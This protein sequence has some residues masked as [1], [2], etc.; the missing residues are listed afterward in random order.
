MNCAY[1]LQLSYD[2]ED[3]YATIES[4]SL[5]FEGEGTPTRE[6]AKSWLV[7]PMEPIKGDQV[8]LT[9]VTNI[10]FCDISLKIYNLQCVC[11]SHF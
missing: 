11:M 3:I 5:K 8:N 7:N 10:Q 9:D 4:Y 1:L 6:V 2:Y